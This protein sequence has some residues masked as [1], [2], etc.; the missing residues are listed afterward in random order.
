[1]PN[2]L[3]N[4]RS[5]QQEF[6]P[7]SSTHALLHSTWSL[8]ERLNQRPSNFP[9][10]AAT[11][12]E[13]LL[14]YLLMG[15]SNLK[16]LGIA[17]EFSDAVGAEPCRRQ[18]SAWPLLQTCS[19][20]RCNPRQPAVTELRRPALSSASWLQAR[21]AFAPH[22]LAPSLAWIWLPHKELNLAFCHSALRQRKRGQ[23]SP[24]QHGIR[25][26]V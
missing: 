14:S 13:R 26:H 20:Q 11:I 19:L 18:S 2:L 1:V 3:G 4:P 5:V 9:T 23:E 21:K 15:P 24:A 10:T 16:K 8:I 12:I 6:Q 25:F 22:N 17:R 7:T